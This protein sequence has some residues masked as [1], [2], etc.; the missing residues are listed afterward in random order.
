MKQY[1]AGSMGKKV[2]RIGKGID[3]RW[4]LMGPG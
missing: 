2:K 4:I 3:K 1:V